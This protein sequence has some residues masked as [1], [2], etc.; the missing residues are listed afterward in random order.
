ATEPGPAPDGRPLPLVVSARSPEALK[1]MTARMAER[2]RDAEPGEFY[3]LAHTST[4]RRTTHPHRAAVLATDPQDAARQLDRLTAAEPAR[5]AVVRTGERGGVAFVF[6]GNASQWPGMAADLL[7]REPA[8]R[9][10]VEETDAALAPHL[11]WSVAKE[12]A[13]PSPRKWQRTEVAQPVLFAVQTGL[14]GLLASHG[15]RPRAVAGHSVGEVAAAHAAGALTLEQAALVIAV[16][17]RTQGATAGRGRMAAVGLPEA[18]A[19]EELLRRDGALEIA[20]VNSESDVTVAGDA[21][22]LAAW[23]A[24]LAGRGVFFRELDLDYAFHSRAMDPI[25]EPLLDALDGLEPAPARIP[26][27]STVTG[28]ELN[29]PELD[30]V[31]WWRNVREPV[32]FAEAAGLLAAEHADVLAEIGPHPVLRPY[33]RRTGATRVATLH[34]DGDGPRETAA[35]VAAVLAADTTTDWRHHFPRPGR[36]VDLP[37]YAWQHERYWHGTA[38]DRVAGTSGSGLL[39]HP[40]VGERMPAPHPVWHGTVEPQLVPWLGDHRIGDDVLMPAAAYVEMALS[41]G[42]RALDRPVEVRHL[43][44]GRP[45]SVPW[46][47]PTP[48]ALQTAV[49]PDDGAVTISVREEH[50]GECRPVVRA[51]VRTLLGTAPDP[52]DLAALRARC[53][54]SVDGPDFYRTCHG[55]GLNCG[56]GFQLI[57]RVDVGDEEALVTYRLA[58]TADAY[59]AHPVL[60]DAPLQATV[61]LA[62]AEAESAAFLPTVFGA[63]RVWRTPAPTGVVH[64]RRRSRGANEMCWDITYADADGTV[65]AEID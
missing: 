36:V 25:R 32:R 31:Y 37:A 2:L 59:T 63:V 58:H 23:G 48:V 12:L 41:A 1:R 53:D 16:R 40:L 56:P 50:G 52:L 3:D 57:D 60:I 44:I 42:R 8:F 24:E 35:A 29:G 4:V 21:D 15:V 13:H 20:G 26:F 19:R 49:T 17:S 7:E 51:Q 22:A 30:A 9:R 43:E 46:P 18:R 28:T 47:D 61:A 62:G 5:G 54:R 11:G 14:T 64:L 27:V 34:R 45:L 65:T 33:L 10:A 38:Q 39:D 6:S 55:I